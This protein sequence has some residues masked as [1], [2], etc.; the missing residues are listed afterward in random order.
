MI[1][2]IILRPN[3]GVKKKHITYIASH[4]TCDKGMTGPAGYHGTFN[5]CIAG[6]GCLATMAGAGDDLVI[7]KVL[8]CYLVF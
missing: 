5:N 4:C 6:F 3:I 7:F 8:L 2:P 1:T